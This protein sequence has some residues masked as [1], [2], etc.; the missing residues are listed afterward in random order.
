VI[1]RTEHRT[2]E[3]MT[4]LA[5]TSILLLPDALIAGLIGMNV[6]FRANVFA[7]SVLFWVVVAV[8]VLLAGGHSV[9]PE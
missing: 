9:L 1:A 6:N 5:L 3:I 4:V 8:I 2:N 7:S